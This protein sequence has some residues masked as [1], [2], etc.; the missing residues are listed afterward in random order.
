ME[1]QPVSGLK[2]SRENLESILKPALY[3][4]NSTVVDLWQGAAR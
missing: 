3:E 2:A 4:L 1:H